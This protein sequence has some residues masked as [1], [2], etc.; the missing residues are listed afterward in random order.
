MTLPS[1][2]YVMKTTMPNPDVAHLMPERA[3]TLWFG[4]KPLAGYE[5][6]SIFIY[7]MFLPSGFLSFHPMGVFCSL[8]R[9]NICRLKS[10]AVYAIACQNRIL[11]RTA[12]RE[13]ETKITKKS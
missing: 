6:P 7:K 4:A 3:S 5:I 12:K 2:I 1:N 13:S 9:T 10:Y 11:T 8:C